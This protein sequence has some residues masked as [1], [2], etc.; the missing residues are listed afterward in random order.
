M[1][2][3][4]KVFGA[5][6]ANSPSREAGRKPYSLMCD[7]DRAALLIFLAIEVE[8]ASERFTSPSTELVHRS[9]LVLLLIGVFGP[10]ECPDDLVDRMAGLEL[11]ASAIMTG[12]TMGICEVPV[13]V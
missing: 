8:S 1:R 12:Q 2:A 3:L 10:P 4:R 7:E 5:N 13:G 11:G 9:V 6:R